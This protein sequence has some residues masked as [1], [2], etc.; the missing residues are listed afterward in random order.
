MDA[1]YASVEQRDDPKLRNK[2]VAVG[3][4]KQRGVVAAASYEA[5]AFGVYSAMPAIIAAKKCPNLIFVKPRFDVY[6]QVSQ[7]IREIFYE[8][9]DLV[10]PLAL[11]EAFLDLSTT[12]KGPPSATLIAKEIKQSIRSKT[13]LTASAG[14]SYNKFLAKIASDYQKP[15]GLFVILPEEGNQFIAELPIKKFFGIGKVT[16]S[17][18][19]KLGIFTGA[20]LRNY[21]R[22]KLASLFGKMG[23]HYYKLAHGID[24]REV[25]PNRERKSVSAERTFDKNIDNRVDALQTLYKINEEVFNRLEKAQITGRTF[26]VKIKYEDFRQ[27]TRSKSIFTPIVSI[28]QMNQFTE[29]LFTDNL[30][31]SK[32]IRL[33]GTGI[34]NLVNDQSGTQLT[35]DF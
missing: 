7:Q 20:D 26:T 21:D 9:T 33:L 13:G 23:E 4:H 2:P 32:S 25:N 6:R 16:A 10:E 18:M 34:S 15:N 30:L 29:D 22:I 35:L 17:K 31:H 14:I 27:I 19:E 24:D 12:R 1:F 3:G 28:D 5:R 8:Y 11:D